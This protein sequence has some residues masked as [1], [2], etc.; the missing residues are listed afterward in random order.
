M[1]QNPDLKAQLDAQKKECPFCKILGKEIPAKIVFEDNKTLALLDIYP[2]LK[3]HTLFMPKE[4]YPLLPYLPAEDFRH[5]FGVLPQLAKALQAAMVAP[6]INVF[7]ANGGAAGQQSYHFL[8]HLLPRAKDDGFFNFLLKNKSVGQSKEV[9]S[10]ANNLQTRMTGYFSQNKI[11]WHKGKGDRPFFLS[12]MVSN[13]QVI[14]EDEKVF[15]ISPNKAG[16]DG[17]VEIYSK[18]EESELGRLSWEDSMHL[19]L[20]ASFTASAVFETWQ[21]QGTNIILKSGKTDDHTSG[22]L[23]LYVLPRKQNDKLSGLLWQPKQPTY[24]L[25]SVAGRI[26][27]KTWKIKFGENQEPKAV[28]KKSI[29]QSV[30]PKK[31]VDVGRFSS[32]QEEIREALRKLR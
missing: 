7:L 18:A 8:M 24:D 2:A 21:A 4:H 23:C 26:K 13:G 12:E 25:D 10:L 3:G 16:V 19:F 30:E 22:R 5:L 32:P 6:A 17:Q 9:E 14:Y 31:E 27:D 1:A 29:G 28:E 15:C 11:S 20:T